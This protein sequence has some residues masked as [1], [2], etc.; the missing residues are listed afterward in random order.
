MRK[1][2]SRRHLIILLLPVLLLSLGWMGCSTSVEERKGELGTGEGGPTRYGAKYYSFEDVLVPG[3]LKYRPKDSV[4]Y[5]TPRFKMGRMFFTKWGLDPDSVIEF[6]MYN[7]E[8]DNW[9][10]VNSFR[11]EESILNFSKPDKTCSIKV[12]EN[13][14]GK[15]KVE[16][17]VGALGE[18]PM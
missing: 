12:T 2:I 16:I 18:K 6:F 5:E 7:M 1:N 11:G 9:K 13:W 14:L 10:L 8:K 4:I 15:T 17:R 3:E